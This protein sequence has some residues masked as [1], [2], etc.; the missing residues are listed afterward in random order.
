MIDARRQHAPEKASELI[1]KAATAAGSFKELAERCGVT[2]GYLRQVRRG[3]K[4]ISFG[5][6]VVLEQIVKEGE[7]RAKRQ[8]RMEGQDG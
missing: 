1:T 2:E 7:R 5:L 4:H 6:Q 8:A 3:E